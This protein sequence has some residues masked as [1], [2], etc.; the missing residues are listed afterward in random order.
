M[1]NHIEISNY[2]AWQLERLKFLGL[3]L[4]IL[5][6]FAF[7]SLWWHGD[8]A[9][10]YIRWFIAIYFAIMLIVPALSSVAYALLS[11]NPIPEMKAFLIRSGFSQI[12]ISI[13]AI[14]FL[15]LDFYRKYI[16]FDHFGP[17]AWNSIHPAAVQWFGLLVSFAVM[18]SP[19]VPSPQNLY[20]SLFTFGF[21]TSFGVTLTPVIIFLCGIILAGSRKAAFQP[22]VWCGSM[23]VISALLIGPLTIHSMVYVLSGLIFT[24]MGLQTFRNPNS[25]HPFLR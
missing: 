11:E 7:A 18:W 23:I 8:R 15:I 14:A 24:I 3:I 20:M 2:I 10:R 17:E 4:Q 1:E 21:P 25:L 19:F 6:L 12:F 9:W 16:R 22:L 5:G 13:A